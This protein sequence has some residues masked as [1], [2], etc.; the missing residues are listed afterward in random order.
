MEEKGNKAGG[1]GVLEV[2]WGR[3]DMP[4][5]VQTEPALPAALLL[6]K[7]WCSSC[8]AVAAAAQP[9]QE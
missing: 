8:L 4:H 1:H 3:A 7:C 2:S 6:V 9:A 5:P